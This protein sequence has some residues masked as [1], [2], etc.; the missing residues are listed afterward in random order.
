M[1]RSAIERHIQRW[2]TLYLRRKDI[3]VFVSYPATEGARD[4]VDA[5]LIQFFDESRLGAVTGGGS[6][7]GTDESPI[8]IT[9]VSLKRP[10]QVGYRALVLKMRQMEMPTETRLESAL[11]SERLCDVELPD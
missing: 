1:A 6:F 4:Y 7:L 2:Y 10:F 9:D 3:V 11:G 5:S 8:S